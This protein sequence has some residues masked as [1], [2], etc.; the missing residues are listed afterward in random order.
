M[1]GVDFLTLV[2]MG[3][4]KFNIAD[5][6]TF[7]PVNS[8][9]QVGA[10][11]ATIGQSKISVMEKMAREISPGIE[12]ASFPEGFQES[13]AEAFLANADIVVDAIDFFCLSARERLY[14]EAR[15]RGKTVLFS[16]PLGFSATF[17]VFTPESPSFH[18]FFDLRPE[19]DPFERL[20]S[21]AIGLAPKALHLKYMEFSADKIAQGIGSSIA[22]ACNL[23][24][25]VLTTELVSIVLNRKP[26]FAAPR[27]LQVDPYLYRIKIARLP[28]GNRGPIQRFKRWFA[29]K[30]YLPYREAILK[31]IK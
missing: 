24:S 11:S 30:Q 9:R 6:D 19:M 4:G 7:S 23:G 25:A 15:K 12:I 22:S 10:N 17:H 3:I 13:N 28:F 2:R 1:G 21:F 20:L 8:N 18:E 14:T 29:R 16:A 26:A 27:Y 31:V 5:F